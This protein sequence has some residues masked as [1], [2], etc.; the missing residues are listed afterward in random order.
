[1]S[2]LMTAAAITWDVF[3]FAV[4]TL[5]FWVP[6]IPYNGSTFRRGS[7]V[8]PA[9]HGLHSFYTSFTVTSLSALQTLMGAAQLSGGPRQDETTTPRGSD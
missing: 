2:V 8:S 7:E 3:S 4:W 9:N 1:M 5:T 6:M